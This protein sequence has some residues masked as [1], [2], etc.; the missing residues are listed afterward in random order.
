MNFHI[1]LGTMQ[2]QN[3]FTVYKQR[4][5]SKPVN[6]MQDNKDYE[7]YMLQELLCI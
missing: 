1:D 2:S 6:K 5:I 7:K 3:E 4:Q